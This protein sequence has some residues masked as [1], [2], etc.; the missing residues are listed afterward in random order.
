MKTEDFEEL[1]Q[2]KT[3]KELGNLSG[4]GWSKLTRILYTNLEYI[5]DLIEKDSSKTSLLHD[6]NK[7]CKKH[8]A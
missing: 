8:G 2:L 7:V 1:K 6:I 4:F 3:E 5:I